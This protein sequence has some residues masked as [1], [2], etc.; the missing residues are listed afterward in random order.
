MIKYLND[1]F[2]NTINSWKGKRKKEKRK[3]FTC[4][5]FNLLNKDLSF[6]PTSGNYNKTKQFYKED[7]TKSSF[8]QNFYIKSSS[9]K[10]WTPKEAHHMVETLIKGF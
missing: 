2:K 8:H 7:K 4:N 10:Q 3:R 9:N 6:C 1:S 5:E